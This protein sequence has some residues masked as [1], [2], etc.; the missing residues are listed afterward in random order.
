MWCRS[1]LQLGTL[2]DLLRAGGASEIHNYIDGRHRQL[3]PIFREQIGHVQ[4]VFVNDPVLYRQ[5]SLFDLDLQWYRVAISIDAKI[6][7]IPFLMDTTNRHK[8][9]TIL[10]F[11]SRMIEFFI[12]NASS[13]LHVPRFV[14]KTT[15]I[16]R[17][18]FNS[19]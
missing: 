18:N 7:G 17:E 4:A 11:Q 9:F 2:W 1:A 8:W 13:S 10:R 16:K 5:V 15:A 6:G 12:E 3:G 19:R 14:L